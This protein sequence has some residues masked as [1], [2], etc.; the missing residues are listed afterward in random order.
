M[1]RFARWIFAL[2]MTTIGAAAQAGEPGY[3]PMA[4]NAALDFGYLLEQ[5]METAPE[6][7]SSSVN[8]EQ[9]QA[10]GRVGSSWLAGRPSVQLDYF[11]DRINS[12]L[13]MKEMEAGVELPLWRWGEQAQARQLGE[14]YEARSRA[15]QDW[16]RLM[17]AGQLR[18][19]LADIEQAEAILAIER[20]ASEDA[21][22]LLSLT[23]KRHAAGEIS[24]AEVMQSRSL[25]LEQRHK[26]LE[27]EAALADSER[28]YRTLTGLTVR[29]AESH[30][31]AVSTRQ[32]VES[33]HPALRLLETETDIASGQVSRE[34]QA[35]KGNPVVAL[36]TRRERGADYED[37]VDSIGVSLTIPFGGGAHVSAAASE[38]RQALVDTQVRYQ[39]LWRELD[40]QLQT[41]AYR[42]KLTAQSLAMAREQLDLN[43]ARWAMAQKAFSLGEVA[44]PQVIQ[45]V[46]ASRESQR[47]HQILAL[48][49]Q[50]LITEYN[51]L[52]GVLP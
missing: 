16:F 6:R 14:A 28:R 21:Q 25:L 11:D 15:W 13:G 40:Q 30:R 33:S 27:A 43:K 18:A 52:I 39:N 35:A 49:Q 47:N 32:Q 2:V 46:E 36:G 24:R 1:K 3:A 41:T 12:Q 22:T 4:T 44:L 19:V 17:I 20:K 9:A 29:P 23:E 50:R 34:T 10:Y 31:E 42:L 26:T 37:Y 38:A 7:L 5:A 45:A 51:Q 8:A 48:Q